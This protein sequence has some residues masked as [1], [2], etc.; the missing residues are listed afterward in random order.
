M[1][2][3][4]YTTEYEDYSAEKNEWIIKLND[5]FCYVYQNPFINKICYNKIVNVIQLYNS[6]PIFYKVQLITW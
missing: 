3:V 1:I 2:N 4:G 6:K 5:M